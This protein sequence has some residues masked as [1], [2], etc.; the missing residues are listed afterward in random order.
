MSSFDIAARVFKSLANAVFDQGGFDEDVRR[1]ETDEKLC[2]EIAKLV[3]GN[4]KNTET[5]HVIDLDADPFVPNGW[6]VEEHKKGG[7]FKWDPKKI[8][9]HLS[10]NQKGDKYVGGN[11]LRRELVSL[12]T[13]NANV[14][15]YLLK[16]PELSPEDWKRDEKGNTRYIFFWGTIYRHSGGDLYVRY[17]CWDR[18][19]WR[20][21][22]GWLDGGWYR[23]SPAAVSA[24]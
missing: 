23:D 14:L 7:E 9:L 1:I 16:H 11:K 18:G 2:T 10:E 21:R 24:S 3:V 20:W 8:Q 15:D 12:P 19:E 13:L 4:D 6:S 22:C 5:N 17:L